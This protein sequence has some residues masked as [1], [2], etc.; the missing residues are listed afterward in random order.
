MLA[1]RLSYRMDNIG[2]ES[3]EGQEIFL[4]FKSCRLALGPTQFPIQWVPSVFP[5]GKVGGHVVDHSLHLVPS[6]RKSG[7]TLPLPHMPSWH[8]Q[9]QLHLYCMG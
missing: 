3:W 1:Q 4:S 2:F 7:A 5:R 9:G 8:R 6:L